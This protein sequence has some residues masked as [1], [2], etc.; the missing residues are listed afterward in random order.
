MI[1]FR[2]N[3]AE[4][5]L[6]QDFLT[7]FL[8]KL[9]EA[10][11]YAYGIEYATTSNAH[12]HCCMSCSHLNLGKSPKSKVE[13]WILYKP[14]KAFKASLQAAITVWSTALDVRMVTQGEETQTIGYCFKSELKEDQKTQRCKN[15]SQ[16]EILQAVKFYFTTQ[17]HKMKDSVLGTDYKIMTTKNV[18]KNIIDY[19]KKNNMTR[20]DHN[21]IFHMRC[22]RYDFSQIASKT[23]KEILDTIKLSENEDLNLKLGKYEIEDIRHETARKLIDGSYDRSDPDNKFYFDSYTPPHQ[24]EIIRDQLKQELYA[25]ESL[26]EEKTQI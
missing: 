15:I 18:H 17:K 21:L 13:Q 4:P 12:I 10:D 20:I 22:N 6:L 16:K 7:L 3:V 19:F 23:Q 8:P 11:T 5:Q 9:E 14:M 1:T 25:V 26:L 24:L 2:P